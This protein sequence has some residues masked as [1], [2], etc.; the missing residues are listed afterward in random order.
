E[1]YTRYRTAGE[2]SHGRVR[3]RQH[4][5][6]V[7]Q[8][9]ELVIGVALFENVFPDFRAITV[10]AV[11]PPHRKVASRAFRWRVNDHVHRIDSD[12]ISEP[13]QDQ[14]LRLA[15]LSTADE[16]D[17]L[18]IPGSYDWGW[19]DHVPSHRVPKRPNVSSWVVN[20]VVF[21]GS[22]GDW[23]TLRWAQ[24]MGKVANNLTEAIKGLRFRYPRLVPSPS[25]CSACV[26]FH[27]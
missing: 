8:L 10:H 7:V 15:R 19:L 11:Y 17:R 24:N 20:I 26:L 13:A 27:A 21:L 18:L 2:F 25:G 1:G 6:A 23:Q 3:Q 14:R 5:A 4:N 9:V 22:L 12:G 16:N